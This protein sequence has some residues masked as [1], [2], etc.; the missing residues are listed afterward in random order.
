MEIVKV[1]KFFVRPGVTI[2]FIFRLENRNKITIGF[3]WVIK[4]LRR[5]LVCLS[6]I[7]FGLECRVLQVSGFSPL[8]LLFYSP[9]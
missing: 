6:K 9:C 1:D 8:I 7:I 2:S 5:N 4:V 3:G